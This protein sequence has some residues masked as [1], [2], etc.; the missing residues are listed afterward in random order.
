MNAI[1]LAI[2]FAAMTYLRV[3]YSPR[4]REEKLAIEITWYLCGILTVLRGM[5]YL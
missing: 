4:H 3:H 1:A 5:D 2:M